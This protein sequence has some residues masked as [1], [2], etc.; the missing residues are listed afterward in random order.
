MSDKHIYKVVFINQEQVYEVY[1][2][3]V[4]QGELYGFVIVEDFIFGEKS[5]I[6]VDPTEEK[7]RLE[8]EGVSRCFIPLHKI[9]R[10]DQVLKRGTAKIVAIG[11]DMAESYS[12][13]SSMLPQDKK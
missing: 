10:I 4:Y 13:V 9:I 6:V 7:L 1:V 12:K 3:S 5:S 2:K 8:F 11:K